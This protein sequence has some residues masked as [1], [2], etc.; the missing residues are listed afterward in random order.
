MTNSIQEQKN[1]ENNQQMLVLDIVKSECETYAEF[2]LG[3]GIHVSNNVDWAFSARRISI[4]QHE[5]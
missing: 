4:D 2:G 1:G 3:S 5:L